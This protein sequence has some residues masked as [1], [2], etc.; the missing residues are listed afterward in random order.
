MA[1]KTEKKGPRLDCRFYRTDGGSEPVREWLKDL[2]PSACT[3]VG[4]AILLV[5]W[6]WPIGKPLVDGMGDGLFEVRV[7]A[8]GNIYRMLFCLDE[9]AMVLLHGFMKKTKKT[10]QADLELARSRKAEVERTS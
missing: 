1:D 4:A 9:S 2:E 7:S 3:E 10:P 8:S 5:Q 6:R